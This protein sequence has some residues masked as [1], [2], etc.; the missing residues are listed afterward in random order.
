MLPACSRP[1]LQHVDGGVVYYQTVC[2]QRYC[3]YIIPIPQTHPYGAYKGHLCGAY[4]ATSLETTI[5]DHASTQTKGGRVL[6][7]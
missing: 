3:G 4:R 2:T 1:R 7:R 5:E 6:R